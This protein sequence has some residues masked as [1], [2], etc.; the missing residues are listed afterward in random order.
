MTDDQELRLECLRICINVAEAKNAYFWINGEG[1][2]HVGSGS[3]GGQN[4]QTTN[5][6]GLNQVNP[7]LN[8]QTFGGN[9]SK[10]DHPI[11]P[12]THGS[13]TIGKV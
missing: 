6:G 10:A 3:I 9:Q 11:G 13:G 5:L 1:R 7:H 12:I 2:Q 8:M 4:Q